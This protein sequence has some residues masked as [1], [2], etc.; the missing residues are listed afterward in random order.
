VGV[1]NHILKDLHKKLAIDGLTFVLENGEVLTG[2]TERFRI[3]FRDSL[4]K[5]QFLADP[6]MALA[7]AYMDGRVDITG[8]FREFIETLYLSQANFMQSGVAAKLLKKVAA[9][10]IKKSQQNVEHHYDIGNDFYKL[11]L[12]RKLIYSCAYFKD[13]QDDLDMAQ[14]QKIEHSLKKL[15][16]KPGDRL[17][18]IGCGWGELMLTAAKNYG[19][20]AC[21]VTLSHEQRKRVE[22]RIEEEGMTGR[23]SVELADYR[24]LKDH[25]FNKII[26]IGMVEHVGKKHLPEYFA[27]AYRLLTENGVFMLHS[28][29]GPKD[30]GMNEWI[31]K[32]IF[33]GGYIPAIKE[34][35]TEAAD[36]GFLITDL[37]SLRRHYGLTLIHWAKN[38]EE[39]LDEVRQ[40]KDERFIRMWRMYLNACA[41][42]FNVANI[43]LHQMVLTK[44]L[45]DDRPWTREYLHL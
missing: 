37:E 39:H 7:E 25:S 6:Q 32:Y 13:P 28:I 38:F 22:E 1:E 42:S 23:V 44:G 15:C 18:D 16:L 2:G 17:L 9:N 35:V 11:W 24:D 41:A 20:Q 19:V 3:T 14:R 36:A 26:S 30:G 34:L 31:N 29:T 5:N 43:D 21:G 8:N 12:D 4:P 10:T 45:C 33:P 27:A 40:S